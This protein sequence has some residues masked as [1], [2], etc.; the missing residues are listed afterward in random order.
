MNV[1]TLAVMSRRRLIAR[2]AAC[3]LLMTSLAACSPDDDGARSG[4]TASTP[5]TTSPSPAPRPTAPTLEATADQAD[6]AG[7]AGLA[8]VVR[9]AGTLVRSGEV[10]LTVAALSAPVSTDAQED[11]SVV[12]TIP[13]AVSPRS[14][15][16]RGTAS[17]RV[18]AVLAAPS[19]MRFEVKSDQ[20]ATLLGSGGTVIG[21]LSAVAVVDGAGARV[22]AGLAARE[23]DAA[24]L[25]VLVDAGSAGSAILTF[26]ATPLVSADW[27][28]RE[29]GRSL[30]VVPAPWVRTGSL[31]AQDALWS[32]LV[33]AQAD[34]DSTT[35]RDQLICHALGAPVK[36]S[37][38]LEPWRPE[39]D[40]FTLLAT[41]CNP[42]P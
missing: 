24:L 3:L 4:S 21:A 17:R 22:G 14:G 18:V 30:A 27:G 41:G 5:T 25:D 33:A 42:E 28:E 34:A 32:A 11:G 26:G 29:G 9:T 35:M 31:A 16:G 7:P 12:L 15:T 36:D 20:S 10:T 40:S 23:I 13:V 6:L 8:E 38:N 39:V 37:W 2:G 19:G 1:P